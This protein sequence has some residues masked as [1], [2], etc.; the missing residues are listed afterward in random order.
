MSN[1]DET[2]YFFSLI[3]FMFFV[4]EPSTEDAVEAWGLITNQSDFCG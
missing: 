2:F 4:G 3:P 1:Y